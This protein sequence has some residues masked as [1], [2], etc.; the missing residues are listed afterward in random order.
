MKQISINNQEQDNDKGKIRVILMLEDN[1]GFCKTFKKINKSLGFHLR[2]N[3]NELQY[4]IYATKANDINVTSNRI[5]L[6]V[7]SVFPSPQQ[8]V[9]FNESI[10]NSFTQSFDSWTACKKSVSTG[11][12][13]Q[14]DIS[15]ASNVISPNFSY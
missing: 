1:C 12:D 3:T 15:S 5:F 9:L 10:T 7:P 2:F 14:V 6:Y 13:Y 11:L 8:Q 4:L